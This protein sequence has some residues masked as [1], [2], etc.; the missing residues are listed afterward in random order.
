VLFH[1]P[2][3]LFLFLPIV[4]ILY[5]YAYKLSKFAHEYILIIAGFFFY[6]WWNIYL[7]PIIIVSII[8]NFYFGNLIKNSLNK[9]FKKKILIFSIFL[10]ILFLAIFKYAD[11]IIENINYFFN[12]N[13][14]LLN[15]PF[16]LAMSFFTF[17]TIAYLVDCYDGNI[18]KTRFTQYS[19]FIIFFPQLIA[20]PIVKYNHMMSQFDD[21]N[22]R[23]INRQNLNLGLVIILIGLFKKIILADNLAIFVENGFSGS[24]SLEFFASWLTSLSFTFQIY[25]DFSGYVDMATGIALLFNI[26]LPVNF[27]SPY[28]ATSIINFWQKWHITLANFLTNYI[29]FPWVK[30]LRKVN[31]LKIMAIIFFVFLIAGIWHGP[32]WLYVVFGALHGFG[33]IVNHVYRKL[34]DYRFN[35]YIACFF[36]FNYINLTFVF[37]RSNNLDNALNIINGMLGFNGFELNNYFGDK[38]YIMTTLLLAAIVVFCFKNTSYLINK[39]KPVAQKEN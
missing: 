15:L 2:V 9:N 4:L 17:Q 22:N 31:F 13:I 33:L 20:G 38:I 26:R 37:F 11:F 39:F 27:N 34:F 3:F 14:D 35:K 6:A 21:Q 29:Y 8:F 19:L 5:Y 10:N 30:S 28:K 18:K 1:N 7:S 36:T 25:F 32:S 24:Q 16:P 23:L 12:S